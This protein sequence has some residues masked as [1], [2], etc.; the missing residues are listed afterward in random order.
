MR[1]LVKAQ[2]G[3]GLVL[4]DEPVP[5]IGPDD[6]L[7]RIR[8]TAICGTDVHIWNWDEWASQTIPVPMIIGHEWCGEIA[9]WG[10]RAAG[11]SR[12]ASGCR[13]RAISSACAAA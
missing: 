10:A 11:A 2:S 12:S 3:P 1:A 8:K 7:V 4:R 6:V 9:K 5:E 13:A